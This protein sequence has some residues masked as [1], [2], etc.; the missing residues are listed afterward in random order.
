MLGGP[1]RARPR[2]RGC[3]CK[4]TVCG[5]A[6][7]TML[8]LAALA[9][10]ACAQ[11]AVPGLLL[12]RACRQDQ[13]RYCAAIDDSGATEAACLRQYYINLAPA[14]RAALEARDAAAGAPSGNGPAD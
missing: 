14:C 5:L 3:F 11:P 12:Q 1:G 10:P 13:H 6:A 9:A 8:A 4:R 2:V 7:R